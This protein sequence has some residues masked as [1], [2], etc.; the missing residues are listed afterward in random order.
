M[1]A[2]RAVTDHARD[3]RRQFVG[4]A[5]AEAYS[6]LV[7]IGAQLLVLPLMLLLWG[8][9]RYGQWLVLY[10]M[11]SFLSLADLGVANVLANHATMRLAA[12]DARGAEIANQTSWLMTLIVTGLLAVP[13]ALFALLGPVEQ[14][15]HGLEDPAEARLALLLLLAGGLAVLLQGPMSGAM[16]AVGWYG[17]AVFANANVRLLEFAV[18]VATAWMGGGFAMASALMLGV[19][20]GLIGG[21]GLWFYARRPQFAPDVRRADRKLLIAMVR[22]S[23]AYFSYSVSTMLNIQGVTVVVGALL[24]PQ[25]VVAVN[26]VRT[27]ARMGRMSASVANLALEP[28][29][30]RLAGAGETGLGGRVQTLSLRAMGAVT[31][32]Y[33]TGTLLLGDGFLGWWTHGTVV[34]QWPLLALMVAATACEMIWFTIQVPFVA[35]NRHTP[36]ALSYLVLSLAGLAALL[37]TLG[38]GGALVVG[39]TSLG[40][41]AAM[42]VVAVA[43][44]RRAGVRQR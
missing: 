23:L 26:A 15:V 32:V 17:R 12:G 16:R 24:G 11:P 13:M 1:S 3:A 21:F 2:S 43:M 38:V 27:L 8:P 22:P 35:T 40:V 10:A 25:A 19:R 39:W 34:G 6:Q 42:L 7:T 31:L 36:F 14:L 5:S 37:A 41:Q 9:E 28:V 20:V 30:A 44:G 29:F 18:L 4:G 33:M